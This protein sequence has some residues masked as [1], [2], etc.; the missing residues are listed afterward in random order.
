ML[1]FIF[2]FIAGVILTIVGIVLFAAVAAYSAMN[3]E[4]VHE[5]NHREY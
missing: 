4:R 5:R 1:E 2:G 3:P